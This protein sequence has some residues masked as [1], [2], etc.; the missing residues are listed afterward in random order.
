LSALKIICIP[1]AAI[2]LL[3]AAGMMLMALLLAM[4]GEWVF[5]I[6]YEGFL[7]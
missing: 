6:K 2:G 7:K 3:V 5:G 4:F 1:F